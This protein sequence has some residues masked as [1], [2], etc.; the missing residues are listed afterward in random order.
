MAMQNLGGKCVFSSE[1]D[2]DVALTY[3]TNFGD[4]P[5]GDITEPTVQDKI[6]TFFDVLCAGF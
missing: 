1:N 6:P 3:R 2:S 5:Y 4:S